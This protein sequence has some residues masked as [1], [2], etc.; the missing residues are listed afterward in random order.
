MAEPLIF[1]LFWQFGV[2]IKIILKE[3]NTIGGRGFF[4]AVIRWLTTYCTTFVDIHIASASVYVKESNNFN[5]NLWK[6]YW[7]LF[8]RQTADWLGHGIKPVL[9]EKQK[10]QNKLFKISKRNWERTHVCYNLLSRKLK[11]KKEMVLTS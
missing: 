9:T 8:I 3:I 6:V 7:G 11:L 4:N 1:V 10:G 5:I 2:L